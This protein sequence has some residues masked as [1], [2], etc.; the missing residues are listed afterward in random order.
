MT[1]RRPRGFPL[2]KLTFISVP[3]GTCSGRPNA[4]SSPE[5]RRELGYTIAFLAAVLLVAFA[6]VLFHDG[7]PTN[8]EGLS[9]KYRLLTYVE[10][11]RR[12]D[13]LLDLADTC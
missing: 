12:F 1:C 7:W 3:A 2:S 11:F 10:H 9:W 13:L 6:P 8:H 5:P 4:R